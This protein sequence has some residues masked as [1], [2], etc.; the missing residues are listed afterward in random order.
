MLS[1]VNNK[2]DFEEEKLNLNLN[3]LDD[4]PHIIFIIV[5]EHLANWYRQK[6]K[7][8][9]DIIIVQLPASDIPVA[10]GFDVAKMLAE[11]LKYPYW[12]RLAHNIC[13]CSEFIPMWLGMRISTLARAML[14]GQYTLMQLPKHLS[15]KLSAH[16]KD[17]YAIILMEL[18]S[19]LPKHPESTKDIQALFPLLHQVFQGAA[20]FD[21]LYSLIKQLM[22]L[23][24]SFED[25]PQCKEILDSYSQFHLV[26]N[27]CGM[28]TFVVEAFMYQHIY[29]HYPDLFN[30]I[31]YRKGFNNMVLNS[32]QSQKGLYCSSNKAFWSLA[33]ETDVPSKVQEFHEKLSR[34]EE[35]FAQKCYRTG[36]V[37]IQV[38]Q[39]GRKLVQ[40][41]GK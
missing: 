4:L 29:T 30:I 32:T 25:S 14:Y 26:E 10:F 21:C 31:S 20:N 22:A 16:I 7:N 28:L 8:D 37:G 35:N 15:S 5:E 41:K 13:G 9:K 17:Q 11:T 1:W 38:I 40:K 33:S 19:L 6:T 18:T 24:F 23:K 12:W 2:D 27:S 36:K 39:F 3:N 34:T